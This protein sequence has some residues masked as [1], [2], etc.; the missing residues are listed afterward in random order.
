[1]TVRRRAI[2]TAVITFLVSVTALLVAIAVEMPATAQGALVGL[3]GLGTLVIT[4]TR[5]VGAAWL[6]HRR[7]A[8]RA[9]LNAVVIGGAMVGANASMGFAP[10]RWPAIVALVVLP[11][12]LI[13]QLAIDWETFDRIQP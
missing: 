6:F 1:M 3:V 13:A 4:S 5:L 12:F 9:F 10:E 2:A 8:A 11:A 7:S